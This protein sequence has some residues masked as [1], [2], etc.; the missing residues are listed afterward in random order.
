ML[1]HKIF[2]AFATRIALFHLSLSFK[3]CFSFSLVHRDKH[4]FLARE[5]ILRNEIVIEKQNKKKK[6]K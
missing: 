1:F 5:F 2:L 4:T 6:M 3:C